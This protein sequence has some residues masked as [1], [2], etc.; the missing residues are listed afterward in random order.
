M[1]DIST[2]PTTANVRA[3]ITAEEPSNTINSATEVTYACVEMIIIMDVPA[4]Y[5]T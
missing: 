4:E 5:C 1:W 2:V 3:I